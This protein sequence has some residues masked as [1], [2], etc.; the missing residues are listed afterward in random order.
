MAAVLDIDPTSDERV[1]IEPENLIAIEQR[2][3]PG[4]VVRETWDDLNDTSK[5]QYELTSVFLK[6]ALGWMLY[7]ETISSES[8][9]WKPGQQS[10]N[11]LMG[12]GAPSIITEPERIC[13]IIGKGRI[14][15]YEVT[16][17]PSRRCSKGFV[18]P[19]W[20]R[21]HYRKNSPKRIP[22]V[23]V[24][25]DLVPLYGIIGGTTTVMIL[26]K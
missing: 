12:G 22:P 20:R 24:R 21:A 6:V 1:E 8:T 14:N 10:K 19:H 17:E 26:K 13:E 7:L 3:N 18:R 5:S 2:R 15:P 4:G 23:L 11:R 16:S 9:V 25:A